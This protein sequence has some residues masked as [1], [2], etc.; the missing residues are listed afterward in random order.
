MKKINSKPLHIGA[1]PT[2]YVGV[3]PSEIKRH[4][5]LSWIKYP[6]PNKKKK[7]KGSNLPSR[8]L[9]IKQPITTKVNAD[10]PHIKPVTNSQV[11]IGIVSN[12]NPPKYSPPVNNPNEKPPPYS[13]PEPPPAPQPPHPYKLGISVVK[14]TS[15]F[16]D[17]IALAKKNMNLVRAARES[18]AKN[19]VPPITTITPTTPITTTTPTTPTT[20]TLTQT[21]SSLQRF[22]N[23]P[24]QGEQ[25]AQQPKPIKPRKKTA[26]EE[27]LESKKEALSN[28]GP[29][30]TEGWWA[31]IKSIFRP[32]QQT[33]INKAHR[34]NPTTGA[35]NY[36]VALQ[37]QYQK[38][39]NDE[40]KRANEEHIKNIESNKKL[41]NQILT[42]KAKKMVI[43]NNIA[44]RI[45]EIENRDGPRIL[46]TEQNAK[47]LR[48]QAK[49]ELAENKKKQKEKRKKFK[50]EQIQIYENLIENRKAFKALSGLKKSDPEFT[51]KFQEYLEK[52]SQIADIQGG[53]YIK[54]TKK[55]KIQ[56][57]LKKTKKIKKNLKKSL[58]N[59]K[60]Y[61][62]H[63]KYYNH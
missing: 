26:K 40:T 32:Q 23:Q 17:M 22:V 60:K 12:V 6:S 9:T 47:E 19:T 1:I 33:E 59:T 52:Q 55:Q 5:N 63:H 35:Q 30:N 31:R 56:K 11:K 54:L 15:N 27:I 49:E 7:N 21:T 37:A 16:A 10:P 29:T 20:P 34:D 48:Q 57:Q 13:Q 44:T 38:D 43:S 61:R 51:K 39:L 24:N 8:L 45:R 62:Y 14:Q 2:S 36:I 28:L 18:K 4:N 3:K 46:S 25:R 53:S 42:V 58:L 50:E 41:A